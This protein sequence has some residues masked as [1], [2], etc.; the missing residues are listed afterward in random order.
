MEI[1]DQRK[2]PL[3]QHVVSIL[4]ILIAGGVTWIGFS[5]VEVKTQLSG[6]PGT[7]VTKE[8]LKDRLG[9]VNHKL[10][11]VSDKID[12]VSEEQQRRTTLINRL[13]KRGE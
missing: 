8:E 9:E 6:L 10:D 1:L 4:V 12:R 5:I 13:L 7:F 2:A 3:S 11:K